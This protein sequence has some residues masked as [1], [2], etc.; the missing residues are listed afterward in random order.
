MIMLSPRAARLVLAS[1]RLLPFAARRPALLRLAGV[2]LIR[3]RL[4]F[5]SLH[6]DSDNAITYV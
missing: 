3:Q 4:I 2:S 6:R 1:P 5:R